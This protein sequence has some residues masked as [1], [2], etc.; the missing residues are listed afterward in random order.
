MTTR[1][2][3]KPLYQQLAPPAEAI[4]RL[5]I[6]ARFDQINKREPAIRAGQVADL[7]FLIEQLGF[8]RQDFA[9]VQ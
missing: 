3:K 8:N 7:V 6:L 5:C 1:S 4:L 2:L 9:E